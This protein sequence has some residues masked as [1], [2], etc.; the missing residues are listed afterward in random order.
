MPLQQNSASNGLTPVFDRTAGHLPSFVLHLQVVCQYTYCNYAKFP[1][2]TEA[3]AV[4]LPPAPPAVPLTGDGNSIIM[5][6]AGAGEQTYKFVASLWPHAEAPSPSAVYIKVQL[7]AD[8]PMPDDLPDS[9]S[10]VH[11]FKLG[12]WTDKPDGHD[13]VGLP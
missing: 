3:T 5:A 13:Q 2:P 4:S 11:E 8:Y 7:F 12:H 1:E 9:A 6:L 10:M